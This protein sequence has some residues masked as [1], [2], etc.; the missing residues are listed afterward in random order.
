[1]SLK[2]VINT[3]KDTK[4]R[5]A[6]ITNYKRRLLAVGEE[7]PEPVKTVATGV[8]KGALKVLDEM[9]RYRAAGTGAL[10]QAGVNINPNKQNQLE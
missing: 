1:M 3:V 4:K 10:Y 7:I 6:T 8:G 2:D 5:N 9:D